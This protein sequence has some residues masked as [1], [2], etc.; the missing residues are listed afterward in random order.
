MTD[1]LDTLTLLPLAGLAVYL[2]A[3]A[4]EPLIY[5]L[6]KLAP[7]GGPFDARNAW[8]SLGIF[9]ISLAMRIAFTLVVPVTIAAWVSGNFAVA[10]IPMAWW[11]WIGLFLLVELV[12]Y[13]DH[14]A[15]H[16]V[17]LLWAMH[18]THHSARRLHTAAAARGFIADGVFRAVGYGVL[19]LVGFSP[20]QIVV[21]VVVSDIL[22]I[23][24]HTE[25]I[26]KLGGRLAWLE[27]WTATPANHRVHHGR[28]PAYIDRNYGHVT[29]IW[30]HVFN[31]Y[32]TEEEQP[33]FGVKGAVESDNPLRAYADGFT[34]LKT[35]LDRAETLGDTLGCLFRPPEWEP[36]MRL[37]Q[38]QGTPL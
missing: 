35:K 38:R 17:G 27:R 26:P 29:M 2:V 24:Q 25:A 3:S 7:L 10:A 1:V 20:L 32:Q 9:S 37:S 31:S 22:G 16:R 33:V 15:S 30:D 13:L 34:W 14:R 4:A 19:A 11:S 36:P 23:F 8:G 18:H 12:W 21:V 28:N 6:A 5:R